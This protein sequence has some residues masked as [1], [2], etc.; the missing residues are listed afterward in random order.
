MVLKI[1]HMVNNDYS[2]RL[3][4]EL[5]TVWA[6]VLSLKKIFSEIIEHLFKNGIQICVT[7]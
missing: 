3:V 4:F 6:A 1:Y 7:Y 5:I 2:K